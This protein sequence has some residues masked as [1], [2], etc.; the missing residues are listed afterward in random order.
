MRMSQGRAGAEGLHCESG[1]ATV[2][3]RYRSAAYGLRHCRR[4]DGGAERWLS[5]DLPVDRPGRDFFVGGDLQHAGDHARSFVEIQILEAADPGD[6][7]VPVYS[8]D[9]QLRSKKFKGIFRQSGYEH[10]ASYS[11]SK[12]VAATLYSLFKI[13]QTMKWS[14]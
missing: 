4:R 8:A 11:N 10:Q 14:A 13:I 2:R 7:T 3:D 1:R 12:V 5:G 6:Q 9:A